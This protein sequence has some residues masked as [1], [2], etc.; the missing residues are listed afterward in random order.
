M[1]SSEKGP[2]VRLGVI[3]FGI[4]GERLVNNAAG[5]DPASV[6]IA[7][8]WDP[9]AA[10][11]ARLAET[12]PA[13]PQMAS[14]EAAMAA[15]DCLYIAT[16]PATHL[17]YAR[18]AQDQGLA[19]FTEKPLA[20]DLEAARAFVAAAE[21]AGLRAAVSTSSSPPPPA[22]SSW[23]NGWTR[24]VSAI[25]EGLR[26]RSPSPPGRGPGRPTPWPGSTGVSRAASPGR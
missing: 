20:V 16:P 3:G 7:G 15:A 13:I 25:P 26:S 14:A 8:V 9:S 5:L 6:T 22:S 21:S 12:L 24:A 18:Q 17:D 23:A 1:G 2:P 10:A 19:V 4:M 11:M